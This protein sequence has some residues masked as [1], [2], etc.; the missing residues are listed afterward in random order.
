[1]TRAAIAG[2]AML[3]WVLACGGGDEAGEP[4]GGAPAAEAPAPA[5]SPAEPAAGGGEAAT[6]RAQEIFSTRCATCHGAQGGGDGPGS[7]GLSPPPRDFRDAEWQA[8]VSDDHLTKIIQYGGA[9]VGR[10]PVMPGNPDLIS[11]PE[12]V[13]A[14]VRHI[15]S[16]GRS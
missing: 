8:S 9:A 15:R 13:E 3:G 11:R 4:A 1:M 2:L 16:L 5:T 7:K 6:A 12:V 10:S 14:L